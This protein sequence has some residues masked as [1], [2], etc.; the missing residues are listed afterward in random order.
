MIKVLI[1]L[2]FWEL[3]KIICASSFKMMYGSSRLD[4]GNPRFSLFKKKPWVAC[5][6]FDDVKG[7]T[8]YGNND[9]KRH[10]HW[11]YCREFDLLSCYEVQDS[12]KYILIY[13]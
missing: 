9:E 8:I 1:N 6:G 5:G 12:S 11:S 13:F 10:F 2:I 7:G 3:R 4:Y